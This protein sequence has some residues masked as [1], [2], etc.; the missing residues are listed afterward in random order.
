MHT[1]L[2]HLGEL[3][4]IL[5]GDLSHLGLLDELCEFGGCGLRLFPILRPGDQIVPSQVRDSRE[6]GG[7]GAPGRYV[8]VI[9][10]R[11]FSYGRASVFASI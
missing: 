9:S 3:G 5:V 11:M 1:C 8:T 10:V 7:F 2:E 4:D 6:L